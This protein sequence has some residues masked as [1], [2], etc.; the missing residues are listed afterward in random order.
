MKLVKT[1]G[2][3]KIYHDAHYDEYYVYGVTVSGDPKVCPSLNMA[4]TIAANQ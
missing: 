2:K 3:I 4:I 1:I